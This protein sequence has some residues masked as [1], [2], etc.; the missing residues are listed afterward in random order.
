MHSIPTATTVQSHGLPYQQA[1]PVSMAGRGEQT[2]QRSPSQSRSM[3]GSSNTNHP[4]SM[5]KES[6]QQVQYGDSV[7]QQG[8]TSGLTDPYLNH[9]TN[10]ES[11]QNCHAVHHDEVID[12]CDP[13]LRNLPEFVEQSALCTIPTANETDMILSSICR[14]L[15]LFPSTM[16]CGPQ[17]MCSVASKTMPK[18]L[19]T[20]CHH[21]ACS[22]IRCP[23]FITTCTPKIVSS[24][25]QLFNVKTHPNL[26][27]T[28]RDYCTNKGKEL[29]FGAPPPQAIKEKKRR[30]REEAQK[31]TRISSRYPN[32]DG[33]FRKPRYVKASHL[34][35]TRNDMKNAETSLS[36]QER[37]LDDLI[38]KL[39]SDEMHGAVQ[40]EKTYFDLLQNFIDYYSLVTNEEEL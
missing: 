27:N 3:S 28:F 22:L 14:T 17:A 31:N 7:T 5:I 40:G 29:S 6:P 23:G 38:D 21:Y 32:S 4:A 11:V 39:E 34:H 35:R 26:V 8:S 36:K 2:S 15:A 25:C 9:L 20:W 19:Q 30:W 13:T 1:N 18:H 16:N 10:D 24:R 37:K 12:F 33:D